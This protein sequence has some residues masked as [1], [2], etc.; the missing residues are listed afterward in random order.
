MEFENSLLSTPHFSSRDINE[1]DT[2]LSNDS[3][4]RPIDSADPEENVP[5]Y[6]GDQHE[7]L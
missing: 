5:I 1:E 6:N 2:L 4:S 7:V 3:S